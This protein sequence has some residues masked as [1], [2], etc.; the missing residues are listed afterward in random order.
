MFRILFCI[1][2]ENYINPH[3]NKKLNDL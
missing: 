3:K 2:K 1:L